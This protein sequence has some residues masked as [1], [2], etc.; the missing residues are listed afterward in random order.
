MARVEDLSEELVRTH[1]IKHFPTLLVLKY[2]YVER[3][4]EEFRYSGP[5]F[6][7]QGYLKMK[8]FLK[9]HAL[10]EPRNDLLFHTIKMERNE[11]MVTVETKEEKEEFIDRTSGFVWIEESQEL[12]F[13]PTLQSKYQQ[14]FS[15]LHIR[16]P[17]SSDSIISLYDPEL[18]TS[19][20]T[21]K[22]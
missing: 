22:N 20:L 4:F 17:N 21:A 18:E 7:T 12:T 9:G 8:E 1:K 10:E 16:S 14:F 15:Y 3:K 11:A 19:Q 5:H 2:N 6:D 13:L